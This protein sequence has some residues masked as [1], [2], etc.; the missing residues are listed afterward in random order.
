MKTYYFLNN[1][2]HYFLE[3]CGEEFYQL[4]SDAEYLQ[5]LE[6][7]EAESGIINSITIGRIV[8]L[9]LGDVFEDMIVTEIQKTEGNHPAFGIKLEKRKT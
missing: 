6:A 3:P 2:Y 7:N 8:L 1:G 4:H 5:Q 9:T